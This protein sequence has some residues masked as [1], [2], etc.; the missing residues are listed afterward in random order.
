MNERIKALIVYVNGETMKKQLR[1]S[2]QLDADVNM[3]ANQNVVVV[4]GFFL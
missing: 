4:V 2:N 1:H 3:N